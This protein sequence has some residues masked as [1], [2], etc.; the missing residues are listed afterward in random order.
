MT[1]ALRHWLEQVREEIVDPERPIIDPHHHLWEDRPRIGPYLLEDLWADT[2]SGHRIE[3]TVFV[4]CRAGYRTDGPEHLRP[5]GE[6]EFVARIAEASA[7]EPEKATIAAIVAHADLALGEAVEAV[8][9][10]HEEAGRGLFRGIRHSGA[11]D[12]HPQALTIPG[13]APEGLYEDARFRAGLARLAALGYTYDTWQYHHQLPALT[14]LAHAVPEA[15]IVINH[16]STPLG[17]G[18]YAG[19][20]EAIFARWRDDVAELARCPNVVAK[21]GALAMPDNGYGWHERATP[22]T[23]D[24][25]LEAHRPWYLHAIECFGPERCMFESNFPVDRASS[26]RCSTTRRQGSIA[27]SATAARIGRPE[28]RRRRRAASRP[29]QSPCAC[30]A[31]LAVVSAAPSSAS[32]SARSRARTMASRRSKYTT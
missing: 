13:R 30:A 32:S 18:P 24:E 7:R 23:S 9:A 11:R 16:L 5:V 12:P 25:I 2:E 27:C 21:L 10:A 19:R 6:T 15:T 26:A 28:R 3:K 17:V 8:L 29:P 14:A 20:R 4:E 31:T 22:P 1:E